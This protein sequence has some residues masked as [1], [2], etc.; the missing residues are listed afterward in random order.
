MIRHEASDDHTSCSQDQFLKKNMETALKKSYEVQYDAV[1]KALKFVYWLASE[2]IPL[3]KYDSF[4]LAICNELDVPGLQPFS[5]GGSNT[6]NYRSYYAANELLDAI[7]ATVDEDIDSLIE[8]SPFIAVLCDESTDISNTARM[9]IDFRTFNP[10]TGEAR[11]VFIND[12]EYEDGSGE[13]F[14]GEIVKVLTS[15]ILI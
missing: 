15:R 12:I 9:T 10:E 7:C 11:S 13:G 1:I 3:S 8:K 14:F 4:F 6:V 2:N 5:L